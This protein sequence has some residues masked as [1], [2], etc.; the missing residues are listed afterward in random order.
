MQTVEFNRLVEDVTDEIK[1]RL[2]RK[3]AEYSQDNDRL[4]NFKR[5]AEMKRTTPINA[6]DGMWLKH[7][8]SVADIVEGRLGNEPALVWEKFID[9]IT[10]TILA[11]AVLQE[12]RNCGAHP[13]LS[14]KKVNE[15]FEKIKAK[16]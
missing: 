2:V 8:V 11:M 12:D 9:N 4:Y 14:E 7:R 1:K 6:L 13:T 5:A 15:I 3:G 10:Y 16:G